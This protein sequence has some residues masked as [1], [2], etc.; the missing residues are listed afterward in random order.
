M[1]AA[2][3]GGK[4]SETHSQ[5]PIETKTKGGKVGEKEFILQEPHS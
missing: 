4:V 1:K 2:S 5:H 3:D